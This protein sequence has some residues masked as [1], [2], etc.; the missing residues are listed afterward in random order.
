MAAVARGS[1]LADG[2]DK[3]AQDAYLED[4]ISVTT[5]RRD[6]RSAAPF[7]IFRA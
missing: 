4:L 6:Q 7:A 2:W 5:V 1:P 3:A